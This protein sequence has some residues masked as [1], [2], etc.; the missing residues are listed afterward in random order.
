MCRLIMGYTASAITASIIVALNI[1][2]RSN[3]GRGTGLIS[4]CLTIHQ[5]GAV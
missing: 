1:F 2:W 5:T 4:V 3:P